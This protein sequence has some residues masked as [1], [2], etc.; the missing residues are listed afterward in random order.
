[1]NGST[2]AQDGVHL[3]GCI[4]LS[5]LLASDRFCALAPNRLEC[6]HREQEVKQLTNRS[7]CS[8]RFS[9][10]VLESVK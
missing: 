9:L 1:M 2:T 7:S 4:V 8:L 6:N 10:R 3:H 5:W